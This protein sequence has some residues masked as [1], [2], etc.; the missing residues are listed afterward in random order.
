MKLFLAAA[1]LIAKPGHWML[2]TYIRHKGFV[3]SWQGFVFSLMSSLRFPVSYILY[4]KK[5]YGK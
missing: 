3:D 1:Y 5:D 4:L 2:T